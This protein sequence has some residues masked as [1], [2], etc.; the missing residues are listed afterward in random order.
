MS[1][2]VIAVGRMKKVFSPLNDLYLKRCG[3]FS[4]VKI[5]Q[6]KDSTVE[7]ES[8]NILKKIPSGNYSIL[9]TPDGR[10]AKNSREI[11]GLLK[12][13]TDMTFIIGGA[14]GVGDVVKKRVNM[15]ISISNLIFPH[16]LFRII[17]L[18]QIYRGFCINNN[19]PYHKD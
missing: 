9:F 7:K 1:I 19:H 17:L 5:I 14:N 2:T 4:K 8:E 6:L 16:Q 10:P 12:S 18:E 11:A 3:F 13:H 15:S